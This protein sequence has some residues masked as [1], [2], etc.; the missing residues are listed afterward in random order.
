MVTTPERAGEDEFAAIY[1]HYLDYVWHSVRRLG[2]AERDLEDVTHE[3][4]IAVHRK[5]ADYDR[6]R[7]IKPWLFGFAFRVVSDYRR[8]PARRAEPTEDA[9]ADQAADSGRHSPERLAERREAM[10]LVQTALAELAHDDRA[11]FI[12]VD[13]DGGAV[14]AVAE[15]L[16][17]PLNTAYSRLRRARITISER[18]GRPATGGSP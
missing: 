2:V 17:I 13:L 16:D 7:P 5:L 9:G 12:A 3:V 15:A 4:F 10:A 14:P 1:R 11:V 6:A 18:L 8:A